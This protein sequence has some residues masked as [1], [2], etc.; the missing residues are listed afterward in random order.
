MTEQNLIERLNF[1][2]TKVYLDGEVI[3][4]GLDIPVDNQINLLGVTP[5]RTIYRSSRQEPGKEP[6]LTDPIQTRIIYVGSGSCCEGPISILTSEHKEGEKE[7]FKLRSIKLPSFNVFDMLPVVF[8][9]TEQLDGEQYGL[10]ATGYGCHG[11]G[12][13]LIGQ[14]CSG[15]LEVVPSQEFR[16]IENTDRFTAPR[17]TVHQQ[18]DTISLDFYMIGH[19]LKPGNKRDPNVPDFLIGPMHETYTSQDIHASKDLTSRLV[20]LGIDINKTVEANKGYVRIRH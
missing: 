1:E 17:L 18:D 5:E 10:L 19:R 9:G 11:R 20:E 16:E 12:V 15:Y 7:D 14:Q 8:S 6:V 2:G 3:F 4:S 13:K